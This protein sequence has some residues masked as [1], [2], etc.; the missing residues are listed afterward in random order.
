MWIEYFNTRASPLAIGSI[1]GMFFITYEVTS[2]ILSEISSQIK[3]P[4][5]AAIEAAPGLRGAFNSVSDTGTKLIRIDT[6]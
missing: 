1:G 2:S 6:C 5:T 3:E 4:L